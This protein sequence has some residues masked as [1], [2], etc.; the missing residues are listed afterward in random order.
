MEKSSCS[1]KYGSS[2]FWIYFLDEND[3]NEPPIGRWSK[4]VQHLKNPW[5]QLLSSMPLLT[6]DPNLGKG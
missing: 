2:S 1:R 3:K 4:I 5:E 6:E